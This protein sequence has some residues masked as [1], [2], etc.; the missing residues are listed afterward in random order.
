MGSAPAGPLERIDK[1]CICNSL[2]LTFLVIPTFVLRP[3]CAGF[4]LGFNARLFNQA[5]DI[6][7]LHALSRQLSSQKGAMNR[8]ARRYA[9]QVTGH[10]PGQR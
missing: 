6:G 10:V 4:S 7:K 9:M 5:R 3:V 2:A 1:G 8:I